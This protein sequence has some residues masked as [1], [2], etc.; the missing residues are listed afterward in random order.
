M[1][2]APAEAVCTCGRRGCVE[3]VA[4]TGAIIRAVAEARGLP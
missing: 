4:S 1:P 3:A 2:R